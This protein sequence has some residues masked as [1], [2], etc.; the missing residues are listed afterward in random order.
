MALMCKNGF[1]AEVSS[2][3]VAASDSLI[4][5]SMAAWVIAPFTEI[6]LFSGLKSTGV[7][8]LILLVFLA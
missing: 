1:L 4:L 8:K 6:L 2:A 5:S 7:A 3:M